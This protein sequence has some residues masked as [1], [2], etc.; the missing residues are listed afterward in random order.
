MTIMKLHPNIFALGLISL[1]SLS[2]SQNEIKPVLAKQPIV[3]CLPD[4]TKETAIIKTTK[5]KAIRTGTRLNIKTRRGKIVFQNTC[6]SEYV[7]TNA[8]ELVAYFA[9]IKYFLVSNISVEYNEYTLINAETGAK[10]RLYGF[11][12]F[13]PDRQRFTAM[14]VDGL[15]GLTSIEIYHLT[16]TGLQQEYQ[17]TMVQNPMQ[18][19]WK[20]N[21]TIEFQ[22]TLTL[23][24]S[25]IPAV[26]Q[27]KKGIWELP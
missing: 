6:N 23:S 7:F 5:G 1:L 13:S 3:R 24:G 19:R 18:P 2:M 20:D 11:P 27:L 17:N 22:R 16:A 14:V 21:N 9:D 4:T 8:Y 25:S 26:L 12:V 10:T 15:N